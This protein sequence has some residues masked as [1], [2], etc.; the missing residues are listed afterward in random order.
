MPTYQTNQHGQIPYLISSRRREYNVRWSLRLLLIVLLAAGPI[1]GWL[2]CID[3][4]HIVWLDL[5]QLGVIVGSSVLPCVLV[6]S[7]LQ[8]LEG[9]ALVSTVLVVGI[10]AVIFAISAG[11]T[12]SAVLEQDELYRSGRVSGGVPPLELAM[13]VSF[14]CMGL[15]AILGTLLGASMGAAR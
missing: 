11:A 1:C 9:R 3:W 15:S 4:Q 8:Q 7:I 13:A 14:L 5:A 2:A 6:A 12:L 10:V